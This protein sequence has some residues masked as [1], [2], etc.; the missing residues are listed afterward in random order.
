VKKF[1]KRLSKALLTVMK[2]PMMR[3]SPI[4]K[5]KLDI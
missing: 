5:S 3:Q 1:R 2:P 4:M